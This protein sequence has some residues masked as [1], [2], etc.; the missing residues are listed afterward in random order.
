MI[1]EQRRCCISKRV[2]VFLTG[3]IALDISSTTLMII[4]S[5]NIPLTIHGIIGYTALAIMLAD[6]ILVWRFW[7]RN[8]DI[9]VPR[10]LNLYTRYA[11]G[12]WVIAS[13]AG[14]IISMTLK[15]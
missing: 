2:L 11:Y 6:T 4:G 7:I 9:H 13:I 8:R 15:T 10:S 12:W 5:H 3:G 1:T 14:A